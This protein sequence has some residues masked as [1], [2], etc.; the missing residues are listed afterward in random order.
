MSTLFI[1]A[2]PIGNLGDITLRTIDLFKTQTTFLCE[3]TRMTRKLFQLLEIDT[4]DKLFMS[5][6][7][8]NERSQIARFIEMLK[9][10]ED[11]VLVTDAGTPLLS[12][13]GFPLVREIRKLK[14]EDPIS[15]S[16]IKVE[17]LPGPNSITT[18]L[19]LSGFPTD[20]FTFV[21]YFP[22]KSSEMKK[23]LNNLKS[24]GESLIVSY[25]GFESQYR[26]VASLKLIREV[27][28]ENAYL[29]VC[30]ELTKKNEAIYTGTVLQILEQ[31]DQK[32]INLSGEFIVVF[33]LVNDFIK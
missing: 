17:V 2:T 6:F 5:N 10:G 25:I 19:V 20:K 7:E 24:S 9:H 29:S 8:H 12:D 32:Q 16:D 3:D 1:A 33:R 13:P 21:G 27:L 31:I 18:A 15:Y 11:L 23:L 28:G 30:K 14:I 4:K 22:R 26:L